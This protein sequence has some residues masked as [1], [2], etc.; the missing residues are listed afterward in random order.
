M[1]DLRKRLAF[2]RF[3]AIEWRQVIQKMGD[4]TGHDSDHDVWLS[5]SPRLMGGLGCLSYSGRC[6]STG[7]DTPGGEPMFEFYCQA[8]GMLDCKTEWDVMNGSSSLSFFQRF[9]GRR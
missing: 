4:M 3:M 8:I 2:E 7:Y 6:L 1:E 9:W 5:V